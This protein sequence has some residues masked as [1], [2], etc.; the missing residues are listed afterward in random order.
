MKKKII[1]LIMTLIA[2]AKDCNILPT[3]LNIPLHLII[4]FLSLCSDIIVY[5]Y[6]GS[7]PDCKKSLLTY[8]V[9]LMSVVSGVTVV[10]F[11]MS[12][13]AVEFPAYTGQLLVAYPNTI[14]SLL[15]SETFS[16]VIVLCIGLVQLCKAFIVSNSFYF[17][18]M[19]H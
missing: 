17:L 16:E 10:W 5:C 2:I 4:C 8:I 13:I 18:N 9:R 11:N 6:Y 14:C 1:T 7:L 12:A 3:Y 19:N 15:R